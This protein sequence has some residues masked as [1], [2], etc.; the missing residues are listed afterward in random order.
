VSVLP[1]VNSSVTITAETDK[2]SEYLEKSI[3]MNLFSF[4]NFG[5]PWLT[6]DTNE[7]P[8]IHKIRL[9]V[10][11]F[12]YYKLIFK[13]DQPGAQATILGYDQ[14]VRFASMAK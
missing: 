13:V 12:V 1:Q 14:A 11:K 2:R 8:K 4:E 7:T 9:K 5:F 10:K 3:S 6:F